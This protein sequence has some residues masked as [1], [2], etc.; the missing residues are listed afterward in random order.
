MSHDGRSCHVSEWHTTKHP[1]AASVRVGVS[2]TRPSPLVS[3]DA[4]ALEAPRSHPE[5]VQV[6]R[7]EYGAS[8]RAHRLF[9]PSPSLNSNNIPDG[10][11]RDR[12]L[13]LGREI[14]DTYVVEKAWNFTR[15]GEGA[16]ETKGMRKNRRSRDL[17]S[18]RV[19]MEQQ[20]TMYFLQIR[21]PLPHLT[22]TLLASGNA[23]V[24]FL[25]RLRIQRL[26]QP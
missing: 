17:W 1:P 9:L 23:H 19:D 13:T 8:S 5:V 7:V 6:C 11:L 22:V 16:C 14:Y 25:R 24:L 20:Q 3:Y 12:R 21:D 4:P 10:T 18:G 26:V 2:P 15:A